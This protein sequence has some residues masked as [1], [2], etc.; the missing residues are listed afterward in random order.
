MSGMGS[1][2]GRAGIVTG[3]TSG[4]GRAIALRLAK[5]GAGVAVA[6]PGAEG[7]NGVVEEAGTIGGGRVVFIPADVTAPDDVERLVAEAERLLGPLSYLYAN[8]GI[9]AIGTAPGTSEETWTA[10]LE[11]NLGGAFRLAK[12]GVPALARAGG[13]AIVL[14]G[15]DLGLVGGRSAVAYCASKGGVVNMTRAL[16]LDC[17]P[18]G[19]RVNCICPGSVETPMLDR[20]YAEDR[21]GRAALDALVPLG[22]VAKVEEIAELALVLASSASTYMTGA[23]VS[24][25]GG[26]TAWYGI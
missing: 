16:A 19:I 15:S 2:G 12:F 22:R 6:A 11:T 20:W 4:I 14:T 3:G 8:A 7:A 26:A 5:E 13:G 21:A 1:F 10:V 24:V 9:E 18:L 25:D 17:A 23:I